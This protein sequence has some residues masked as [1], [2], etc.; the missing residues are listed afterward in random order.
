MTNPRQ[1]RF[2]Q[3]RVL[4]HELNSNEVS[5]AIRVVSCRCTF[6]Q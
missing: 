1:L 4:L 3:E 2:R 6:E 5:F